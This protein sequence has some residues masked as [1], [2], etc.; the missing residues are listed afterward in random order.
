MK[1]NDKITGSAV[2]QRKTAPVSERL[3]VGMALRGLKQVDLVRKTGIDKGSISHYLSG[4]YE[5]KPEALNKLSA[6]LDVS[7]MWLWGYDVPMERSP[8]VEGNTPDEEN[9]YELTM[10]EAFDRMNNDDQAYVSKWVKNFAEK[11]SPPAEI[12]LS[13]GEKM[14]LDL[15]RR[16]PEDQ[17]QLVL[18][19][20]RAAL[21][22]RE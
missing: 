9:P 22:A 3:Q 17:Q 10:L 5:P 20:I 11:G 6:A 15:F 8:Q 4:R 2:N 18:Q 13:E 7:E 21:G 14:L 16:V 12:E 1:I 19:M